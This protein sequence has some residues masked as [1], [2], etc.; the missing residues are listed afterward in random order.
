MKPFKTLV[1]R[2][3]EHEMLLPPEI[4]SDDRAKAMMMFAVG[5]AACLDAMT[6][7]IPE[8]EDDEAMHLISKLHEEVKAIEGMVEKV[9]G[10]RL[11]S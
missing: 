4:P 10:K 11:S 9:F 5:F 7:E 2:W 8:Y 6:L 1:G 3:K